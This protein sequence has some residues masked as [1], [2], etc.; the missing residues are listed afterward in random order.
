MSDLAEIKALLQ[1]A[2][3]PLC[4]ELLPDGKAKGA[5]WLGA[6]NPTRRDDKAGSFWVR[7]HSEAGVWKDEATGEKGDVVKLV[8]YCARLATTGEALRWSRSFLQLG[9]MPEADRQRRATLQKRQVERDA[10]EMAARQAKMRK[11][12]FATYLAATKAPIC[13]SPVEAY[14]R[15]RGIDIRQLGRKPGAL[16]WLPGH[17]HSYTD[18]FWP[19]MVAGFTGED[20]R[21][22]AIHRTFLAEGGAGKAPVEPQRMIWPSFTGA[23]IRLWR[24]ESGLSVGD[25]AKHGL[26]ETLVL[27]EGV[28][29]GLS[30]AL[31]LPEKRVWCAGSLGNLAAICLP[32]AIDDVVIC[33]DNDWGKPQAG[34]LLDKAVAAF[35]AQGRTVRIARAHTGKD[36][37]D[38]LRGQAG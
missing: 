25:A 2:I 1:A 8:Q 18:T 33:A 17:R 14:L 7:L 20:G 36:V 32:E 4:Q 28:E 3:V 6:R 22:V 26:R 9:E 11:H 16:G 13:G 19:V 5:Y 30:I 21:I 34:K 29:D 10:G 15:T 38:A 12:A 37:N 23:A 27:V 35:V 24:G 31:A